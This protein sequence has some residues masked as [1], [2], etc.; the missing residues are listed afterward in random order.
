M[1]ESMAQLIDYSV[2]LILQY[3]F[4][5]RAESNKFYSNIVNDLNVKA[6]RRRV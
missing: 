1:Y 2:S 4:V 3:L 6:P 5:L